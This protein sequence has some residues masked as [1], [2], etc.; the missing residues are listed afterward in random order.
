MDADS[1][2]TGIYQGRRRMTLTRPMINRSRKVLWLV[3]GGEKA[4]MLA[5]LR[6][7]DMSIPA[8]HIR[9]DRSLVLTL[10]EKRTYSRGDLN[11]A[12]VFPRHLALGSLY[13][14]GHRED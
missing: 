12:E 6:A 8:G 14:C 10:Q 5:R 3:T 11:S 9:P 2:V 13:P 7:G 1:A 4:G